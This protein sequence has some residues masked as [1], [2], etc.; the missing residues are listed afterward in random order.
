MKFRAH[1]KKKR[2]VALII[3]AFLAVALLF[4]GCTN[5]AGGGSS[6]VNI[7]VKGDV[8]VNVPSKP[9]AVL[10]GAKWAEVKSTVKSKVS[11]QTGFLIVSWHLGADESAPELK[12]MDVFVKDTTVFVKSRPD[13]EKVNNSAD[14]KSPKV[15]V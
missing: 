2:V 10:K 8:N 9:V 5:A 6:T 15:V 14:P 4:T 11:T 12:D 1:N 7:T 3:A 13:F